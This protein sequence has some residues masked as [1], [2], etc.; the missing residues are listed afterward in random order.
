[1]SLDNDRMKYGVT[2]IPGLRA[3]HR[4]ITDD[5]RQGKG[6]EGAIQEVVEDVD[7]QLRQSLTGWPEGEGTRVHVVITIERE[8]SE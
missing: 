7:R 4:W 1:M 5:C 2:E 3:L 8:D 6:N